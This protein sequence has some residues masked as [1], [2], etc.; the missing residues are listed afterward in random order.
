MPRLSKEHVELTQKRILRSLISRPDTKAKLAVMTSLLQAYGKTK[1]NS[2]RREKYQ[3]ELENGH[4]VLCVESTDLIEWKAKYYE[5]KER[6]CRLSAKNSFLRDKMISL[7]EHKK[8]NERLKL[9]LQTYKESVRL[10]EEDVAGMLKNIT[11]L[12]QEAKKAK[13]E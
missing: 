3:K 4:K 8:E 11:R 6:C 12:E 1:E 10:A 13:P 7:Q 9:R 5:E 2:K